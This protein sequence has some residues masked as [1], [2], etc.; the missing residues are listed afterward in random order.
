MCPQ[1]SRLGQQ[2]RIVADPL[3]LVDE[4]L[5]LA[6]A[7]HVCG[8]GRGRQ[9]PPG[10]DPGVGR[11]RGELGGPL[12]GGGRGR[13]AA[14]FPGV[15]GGQL[16]TGRNVVIGTARGRGRVPGA[17]VRVFLGAWLECFC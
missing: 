7:S 14:A 11:E 3:S 10:A 4:P 13:V 17:P 6:A 12:I 15:L 1:V 2:E 16:E 5:R 9:Q 8:R